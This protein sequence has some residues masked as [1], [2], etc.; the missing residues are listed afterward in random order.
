MQLVL[1]GQPHLTYCTNIHRGET[2][3][4]V[5]AVLASN[6][7]PIKQRISPDRAMGIGLRLSAIAARKLS[8]PQVLERFKEFLADG[9][10]YVFTINAF[11]YGPFHG[12]PV[13][14]QVYEPD[15]RRAE[16]LAYTTLVAELLAKLVPQGIEGSVSTVPGAFKASISSPVEVV[17]IAEAV[18]R[19]A[20]YLHDLAASKGRTIVLALEPEPA[21]LLETTDEAIQFFEEHLF[22]RAATVLFGSLTGLSGPAAEAAMRRHVGLCF[23]VCHAAV[24]FE[25][26]R[27]ALEA[28]GRAGIRLAKLQL[29]AAL[30][31]DG[32][33][34]WVED[35]L[36][37][38]D[39]GI[40]L[41]QTV[42]V[43]DG[44]MTR[45]TDLPHALAA[46]RRQEAGG[47]WRI[48][49]HVP[50]FVDRVGAVQSTQETL[51]DVL[52]LCRQREVSSH[53][54]VETYTWGVL[55]PALRSADLSGDIAR[56]LEWVRAELGA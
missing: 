15:W 23:D 5:K 17:Q 29:S 6:L 21:C 14:E 16:R 38:F 8:D 46:L 30:R 11:P 36:S 56:E 41:H 20:A 47:Q 2:W 35:A 42:E 32:V 55:P 45:H 24:G 52:S 18:V 50:V 1:P 10:F 28:I 12:L 19:C 3:P 44:R 48:H 51:R 4:E 54:E 13:K 43:R 40:Y 53:L 39:D 22:S 25:N 37:K 31:V 33:G 27:W 7:P 26:T 34:S 9:D 49:C